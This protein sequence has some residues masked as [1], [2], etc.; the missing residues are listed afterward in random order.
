MRESPL[1]TELGTGL[2]LRDLGPVM[3]RVCN[4]IELLKGCCDGGA[5]GKGAQGQVRWS[6]ILRSGPWEV[7]SLQG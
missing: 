3:G 2:T 1:R 4:L 6:W 7:M 5:R